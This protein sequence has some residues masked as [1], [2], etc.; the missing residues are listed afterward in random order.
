MAQAVLGWCLCKKKKN[1]EDCTVLTKAR[2]KSGSHR[3]RSKW[4]WLRTTF[5]LSLSHL[6][7]FPRS[8]CL[9]GFKRDL[10]VRF[11]SFLPADCVPNQLVVLCFDSSY[12]LAAPINFLSS[13]LLQLSV[14]PKCLWRRPEGLTKKNQQTVSWSQLVVSDSIIHVSRLLS[15]SFCNQPKFITNSCNSFYHRERWCVRK[16]AMQMRRCLDHSRLWLKIW[17]QVNVSVFIVEYM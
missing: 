8:S 15:Q 1:S 10:R 13:V 16:T 7:I 6:Q 5:T 17:N 12:P 3:D 2:V 11:I 14:R 4:E 9:F